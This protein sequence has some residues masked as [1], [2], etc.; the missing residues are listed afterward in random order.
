[1]EKRV[2]DH[3]VG[4]YPENE[5]GFYALH[6]GIITCYLLACNGGYLLIDTGFPKDYP[7]F[8]RQLAKSGVEMNRIKYLLLTH[9]HDD[10]VGFAARL[11]QE[12]GA[13]C[14]VHRNALA[15]LREGKMDEEGIRPLNG[16][17]SV[18]GTLHQVI[19][20][21]D[22]RFEPL[23]L[24]DRD[25]IVDGDEPHLLARIGID[26]EIL[27]TPG[28]SSDS[29]SVITS[30][31]KAFCGDAAMN[32]LNF[33]G[34][35]HRPIYLA[36]E[37]LMFASWQKMLERGAKI[38]YPAHGKPFGAERLRRSL[39]RFVAPMRDSKDIRVD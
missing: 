10:H 18:L 2:R 21:R 13:R 15:P 19:T 6:L 37:Q 24:T 17:I 23:F 5:K 16:I 38:F 4:S 22:C 34:C 25:F 28:H 8:L 14:I 12:T 29:I 9:N 3:F 27:Y 20:R 31:G 33:A 39:R 30:S 32:Y 36:D 7:K 35:R 26:A 11:K 1:M